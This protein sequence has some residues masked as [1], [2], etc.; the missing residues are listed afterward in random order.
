ML[1]FILST[2]IL[3]GKV[4]IGPNQ[5]QYDVL[6]SDRQIETIIDTNHIPE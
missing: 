1:E 3:V 4:D 2:A 6:H 5:V